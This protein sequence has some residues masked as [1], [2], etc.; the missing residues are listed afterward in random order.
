MRWFTADTHFG[1]DG[2]I[3]KNRTYPSGLPFAKGA[4]HDWHILEQINKYVKPDDELFIIGDFAFEK[5]GRYRFEIRCKHVKFIVGNHDR[6]EKSKNVFGSLPD[7]LWTKLR[8]GSESLPVVLSH[9]PQAYWDGSH[10][11]TAHLYGHCHA[12]REDTLD[13]ILPG[14]R[15]MDVGVDNA[16][17]LTGEMRPWSEAEL[18]RH[19]IVRPGHDDVLFYKRLR[20]EE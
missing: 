8:R 18:Y 1:H 9:Y 2:I 4:D 10:H 16:L 3:L 17:R 6:R 14:R 20:G 19:M 15:S 7:M 12:Q 13:Y 11:G 5:P